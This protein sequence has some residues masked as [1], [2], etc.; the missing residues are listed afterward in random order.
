MRHDEPF[1]TQAGEPA[2]T[3][4]TGA[5]TV[6]IGAGPGGLT[7]AYELSRHGL[8]AVVYEM[9]REA[10]TPSGLLLQLR[11][12]RISSGGKHVKH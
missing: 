6:V 7:A 5:P 3:T 10:I 1:E 4:A 11:I 2:P 12:R 9:E 8:P